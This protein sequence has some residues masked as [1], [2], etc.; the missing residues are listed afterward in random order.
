MNYFRPTPW[1]ADVMAVPEDVNLFIAGGR[2]RGATTCA[3]MLEIR[4]CEKYPNSH[5]LFVRNHL[6][7]LAEVEDSLQMLLTSAYGARALKVNRSEH[8]FKMP[9]GSSIEFAPLADVNDIA[10]LQG[11]SFATI[12]ADEVGNM[13]PLQLK[14][15][16]TLRAN[17]RGSDCP[18]RFVML[19]NPAGPAHA[20][21]K[22]RF[23]DK[24]PAWIPT[25]LD[26]G[27]KWAFT[28]GTYKDNPHAPKTY[29][30]DLL[31]SAGRDKEL[32]KAWAD[33][34]WNIAR[35]AILADVIDEAKQFIS[36]E[37]IGFNIHHPSCYKFLSGDWGLSSPSV[38]MLCCRLLSPIGRFPRNSLIL[39]DQVSSALP[40]DKSVGQGWSPSYLADQINAMCNE[41]GVR[42][43]VG[44]LDDARGLGD[45]TLI[46]IMQQY[47][48]YF[49]RPIKG[50]SENLALMREL[51][52]NSKEGNGRPGLWVTTRCE[53]WI[54]TV[55]MLPRD[56]NRPDLPDTKANDH[57]FDASAY[58][59]SHI[60]QILYQR[61]TT[62]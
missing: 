21:L 40:D 56:L 53:D 28:P 5:H 10:K 15:L 19:A 34:S 39:L 8:V 23:V 58:A 14:W 26:D 24:C 44:V 61:E 57:A 2:A 7:S 30:R 48:L 17:L 25:L 31:A 6:R 32:F 47:G 13:S 35:G 38:V 43:R 11:R 49:E 20:I 50:R 27:L 22:K 3:E 36:F 62:I 9:N 51:L 33:G 60:P 52:F 46:G 18:K 4:A 1:Q 59:C 41:H 29:E 54:E 37:N 45:E 55:P 16:D 42:N 12:T